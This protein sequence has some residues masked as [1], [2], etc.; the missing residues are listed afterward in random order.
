MELEP[1]VDHRERSERPRLLMPDRRVPPPYPRLQ[2]N[3]GQSA[4]AAV[5]L[6]L[7]LALVASNYAAS[8][9]QRRYTELFARTETTGNNMF[10]T[11]RETLTYVDK[12]ERYLLG[13]MP[14]RD[15]QLARALLGQRLAVVDEDEQTA[16]DNAPA[17][18]LSALG[19]MDDAVQKI[20]PGILPADQRNAWAGIVLPRAQALSDAARRLVDSTAAQLHTDARAGNAAL[21]QS[22]LIQLALLV[23]TVVLAAALLAWVAAN[24]ARQYRGARA[25]VDEERNT[26][27]RTEKNSPDSPASNVGRPGCWS[28]SP[29][30]MRCPPCYSRS[31]NSRRRCPRVPP[32]GSS[33]APGR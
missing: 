9:A 4:L 1:G 7:I 33:P 10:Y 11:M 22:R 32:H 21:L 19:A 18:Y 28:G 29:P 30:A 15:V 24:V 5:V 26:L 8:A 14:R 3:R 25:A 17:S 12:A 23:A 16:G 13:T 27:R 20:P 31:P 2:L 6:L